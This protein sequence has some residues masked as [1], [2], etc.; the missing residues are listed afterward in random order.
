MKTLACPRTGEALASNDIAGYRYYSCAACN[1][2]WV[3]GSAITKALTEEG[4]A[5]VLNSANT[6]KSKAQCPSC[7]SSLHSFSIDGVTLDNCPDCHG[8]WLDYGEATRL[9]LLFPGSS[10][11]VRAEAAKDPKPSLIGDG[12]LLLDPLLWILFLLGQ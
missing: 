11:I 3:P 8:V 2:L 9:R 1:G 12:A 7:P 5:K 10:D 6:T 4:A